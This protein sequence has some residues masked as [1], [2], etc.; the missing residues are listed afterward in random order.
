[1]RQMLAIA[2]AVL[3][4][5][6]R[7]KV[8][9]VVLVFAA[10]LAFAVPALPSYGGE[11]VS[12]V[13]REISLALMFT[14]ALV[15]GLALAATRI[16]S[17][18]ERRTVFSLLARDVR[19]WQYVVGTWLGMFAVV[20]VVIAAFTLVTIATGYV[21]YHQLMFVLAEGALAIWLET[22]VVMA[23]TVLVSARFNPVTSVI[24]ALAFLFI[25]HS[26]AGLI[27][28]GG[29][30]QPPVP[31][32]MPTLDVFNVINPV[33]HGSGVAL[34]YVASMLLSFVALSGLLLVAASATFAGRDL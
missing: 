32:W 6:V 33:A 28:Y 23:L 8:T 7:R 4:D 15:V 30:T 29:E 19:R 12:A 31:W 27:G 25:G 26:V 24:G 1:M 20:G 18:V 9:W 21:V 22:G 14:A 17:E 13:F 3:A 34:V 16:P 2:Q 11:V 10:L 5:A